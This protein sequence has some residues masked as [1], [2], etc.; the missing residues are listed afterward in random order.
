[1]QEWLGHADPSFT[2]R[3]E[4]G[5]FEWAVGALQT[6]VEVVVEQQVAKMLE[7]RELGSLGDAIGDVL[8]RSYRFTDGRFKALWAALTGDTPEILAHEQRWWSG[9]ME[10][11]RLRVS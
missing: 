3:T 1:V 2:L 10:H 6:A 8:V 5:E 7:W 4:R 11:V 9:Y